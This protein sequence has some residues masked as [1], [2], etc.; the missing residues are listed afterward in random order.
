MR[1]S[2]LA[3]SCSTQT[4]FRDPKNVNS[5]PCN[6]KSWFYSQKDSSYMELAKYCLSIH[7]SLSWGWWEEPHIKIN[8]LQ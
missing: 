4:Q 6:H 5:G 8:Y 2:F 7:S 3:E 1:T